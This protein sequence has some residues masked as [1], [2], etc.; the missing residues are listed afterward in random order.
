M[1]LVPQRLFTSEYVRTLSRE[2]NRCILHKEL[3][4]SI[5]GREAYVANHAISLV[6]QGRQT[7]H[8]YEE[9]IVSAGKGELLF[10]PRG[11]YYITDLAA[12]RGQF[13]SLLFYFDDDIIQHFLADV[14]VQ[15]V[16]RSRAPEFLK[17]APHPALELFKQSTITQ[18]K[19]GKLTPSLLRLKTLELLHLLHGQSDSRSFAEFLFRLTLPKRRQLRSFMEGNYQKPLGVE[20]FA[21]LTGRSLSTFRRDF[22][23]QFATT[24]NKW[25][26]RRRLEQALAL[27]QGPE[28][29]VTDL[30][31][32]VGYENVSYFIRAFRKLTG[33]SPK[34]YML[35]RSPELPE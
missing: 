12:A 25:L 11:L 26:R 23:A 35:H 9:Q 6:L 21:Y 7:I 18:A 33:S 5:R 17:F 1:I 8:T 24:P 2:G 13:E 3:P 20:D 15:Q 22:K 19:H 32:A 31:L 28:I 30:A 14:P 29:S 10:L 27:A 34:Q 4:Q 16:D